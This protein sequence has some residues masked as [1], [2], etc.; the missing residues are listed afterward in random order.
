MVG[1]SP[2]SPRIPSINTSYIE[3]SIRTQETDDFFGVASIM[4]GNDCLFSVDSPAYSFFENAIKN[5]LVT[6]HEMSL[7]HL[8]LWIFHNRDHFLENISEIKKNCKLQF[9]PFNSDVYITSDYG[10]LLEL[11]TT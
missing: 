3:N 2:P 4:G 11:W 5:S 1:Y 8:K 6:K 7:R 10:E 9:D